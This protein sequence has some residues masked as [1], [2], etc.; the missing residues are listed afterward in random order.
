M[1]QFLKTL[2]SNRLGIVLA[3]LNVC[4]FIQIFN[5]LPKVSDSLLLLTGSLNFP[6]TFLALIISKT[7]QTVFLLQN[8]TQ[9]Q[10]MYLLLPIFIVFQWLFIAHLAKTISLKLKKNE[11]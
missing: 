9:R 8:S 11:I 1:R 5:N 4:C 3:T 6:S 10:I 2:F 7:L